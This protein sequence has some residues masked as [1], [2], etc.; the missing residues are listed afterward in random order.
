M[1]DLLA[2]REDARL[3]AD[4]N[5]AGV[6]DLLGRPMAGSKSWSFTVKR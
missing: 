2:A 3:S 6:R 5:P 1:T 4:R